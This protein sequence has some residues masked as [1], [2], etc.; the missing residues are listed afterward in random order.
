MREASYVFRCIRGRLR[1]RLPQPGWWDLLHAADPVALSAIGKGSRPGGRC[2]NERRTGCARRCGPGRSGADHV[3][4]SVDKTDGVAA[5]AGT[6]HRLRRAALGESGAAWI[7]GVG[8]RTVHR[9]DTRIDRVGRR[10]GGGGPGS[11]HGPR[12]RPGSPPP[13]S[14]TAAGDVSAT[15][16]CAVPGGGGGRPRGGT[17]CRPPT[18][19][20]ARHGRGRRSGEFPDR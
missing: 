13:A 3:H 4:R 16:G 12:D 7:R 6:V 20:R 10:D 19:S 11:R 1:T 15:S 17:A 9:S 2:T 14:E 8:G 5:R 18:W